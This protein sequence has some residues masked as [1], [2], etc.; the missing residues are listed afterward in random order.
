[1]LLKQTGLGM[2]DLG[3][4]PNTMYVHIAQF[5]C[6]DGCVLYLGLKDSLLGITVKIS[7]GHGHGWIDHL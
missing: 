6:T 7:R 5:A 2:I 3:A 1:M 4:T